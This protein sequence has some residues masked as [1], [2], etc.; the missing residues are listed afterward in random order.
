MHTGKKR[1][2]GTSIHLDALL[3]DVRALRKCGRSTR[4]AAK[5]FQIRFRIL[6]IDCNRI[7]EA[8]VKSNSP[9]LSL[10]RGYV[11]RI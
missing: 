7:R 8:D 4:S 9:I 1:S 6:A 10:N 2:D 3:W 5:H 11:D